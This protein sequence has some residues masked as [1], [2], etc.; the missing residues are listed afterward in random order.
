MPVFCASVLVTHPAGFGFITPEDGGEDVFCHV[1]AITD[2][3][4]LRGGDKVE[5]RIEYDEQRQK[6][7]AAGVVGGTRDEG[8]GV[9]GGGYGG[10]GGGGGGGYDR[11]DRYDDRVRLAVSADSA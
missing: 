3:N 7:R 2:G 9:G 4:M 6:H 8:G 10:G 11:R 5:F 1:S